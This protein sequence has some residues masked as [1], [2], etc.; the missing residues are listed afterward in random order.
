MAFPNSKPI[1]WR[2]LG[3]SDAEDGS[4]SFA[5]AMASLQNL[6]PD[7]ATKSIFVPRVAAVLLASAIAAGSSRAITALLQFGDR[8]YGMQTSSLFPGFDAPFVYDLIAMT[9]IPISGITGTNLPASQPLTGD[10][11]PPT[12]DTEGVYVLFTHPGFNGGSNG[13][14]GWL[15]LTNRDA[16]VWASGNTKIQPLIAPPRAVKIFSGRA[17]FAVMN[18]L[19]FSDAGFPLQISNITQALTIGDASPVTALGG[20]PLNNLLGGSIQSLFAFKGNSIIFQVTGDAAEANLAL[21]ELNVATGTLAPNTIAPTP[22]GLA[23]VAPDGVR[24]ISFSGQISPPVGTEG[25]GVSVPFINCQAQSRMAAASNMGVL[26]IAVPVPTG[27]GTTEFWYHFAKK[28]WTGPHTFSPQLLTPWKATFIAGVPDVTYS[29]VTRWDLA[30]WDVDSWDVDIV[31]IS[32]GLYRSDVIPTPANSIYV[33]GGTQLAWEYET[34]LL[35]DNDLMAENTMIETNLLVSGVG[36]VPTIEVDAL[37]AGGAV[38]DSFTFTP[39]GTLTLWNEFNWNEAP[40]NGTASPLAPY[41]L[42][43]DQPIVFKQLQIV[44]SGLSEPD[45]RIGN[46]YMRHQALEYR[47][48]QPSGVT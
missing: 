38:L 35:P 10:W 3:L 12:V 25:M 44:A 22:E 15:D 39:T 7:P 26:R 28:I 4:N 43:W 19:Q 17:Y 14:F 20:L 31:G 33:E 47:Q 27:T 42:D 48:Q 9:Y 23:F 29:D 45:F 2:P 46:L 36:N 30:M 6:V 16:P 32:S 11:V 5:G 24:F 1:T 41:R 21:N 8:V 40:W 18:F 37:D 13:Y 34:V